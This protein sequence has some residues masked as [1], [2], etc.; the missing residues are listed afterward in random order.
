M[1]VRAGKDQGWIDRLGDDEPSPHGP[2]KTGG[3]RGREP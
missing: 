2:K 3:S 1:N